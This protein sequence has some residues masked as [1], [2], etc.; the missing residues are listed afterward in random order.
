M[1]IFK[2]IWDGIAGFFGE[3]WNHTG[4]ILKTI[5]SKAWKLV[6]FLL[7]SIFF[8]PSFFIV[9]TFNKKWNEYLK[10]LFGL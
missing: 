1:E 6:L 8:V 7:L 5:F 3:L 9:Q 10:E 4:D 2:D